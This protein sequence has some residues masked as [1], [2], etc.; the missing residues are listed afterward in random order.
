LKRQEIEMHPE[1]DV[2]IGLVMF[3]I[4]VPILAVMVIFA[5]RYAAQAFQARAK[6]A[7]DGQYQALADRAASAQAETAAT[8]AVVK[9]QLA[10][11]AASLATVE[12]VLKQ[13]G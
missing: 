8:L 4:A 7:A 5:M 11:I 12:K 10:D 13:V 9:A 6:L 3:S 2:P 1:G